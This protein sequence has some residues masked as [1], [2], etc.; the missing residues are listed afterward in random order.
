MTSGILLVIAAIYCLPLVSPL[1]DIHLSSYMQKG[2]LTRRLTQ[3]MEI[4]YARLS[5]VT[6]PSL[7]RALLPD[8]KLRKWG[9]G[10]EGRS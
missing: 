10:W 7:Y 6:L 5:L 2:F 8:L 4:I 1:T 3:A 9:R